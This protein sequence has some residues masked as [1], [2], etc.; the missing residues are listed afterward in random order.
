MWEIVVDD[1]FLPTYISLA[2]ITYFSMYLSGSCDSQ[3][4]SLT[5]TCFPGTISSSLVVEANLDNF[6]VNAENTLLTQSICPDEINHNEG[7]I[8]NLFI[9]AFGSGNSKVFH[10]GGLASIPF[11]GKTGF[12]AFSHHVPNGSHTLILQA[13]HTHEGQS[14]EGAM[15]R[16]AI[17]VMC[18]CATSRLI[19]N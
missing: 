10:L 9:C 15:C 5:S 8:T 17:R 13:P 1:S 2:F 18:H 7:D 11:L 6:N 16:V 19:P 12:G 3:W 14:H 4:H